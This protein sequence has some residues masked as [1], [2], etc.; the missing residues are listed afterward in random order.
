MPL[1]HENLL[2]RILV[3][4]PDADVE[5]VRLMAPALAPLPRREIEARLAKARRR[6]E[7]RQAGS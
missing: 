6:L 7:K 1:N 2:E 5:V 3:A 4:R